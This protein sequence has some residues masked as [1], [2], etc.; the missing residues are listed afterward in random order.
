[1]GI[2]ADLFTPVFA[3]SRIAGWVAHWAE[4]LADNKI[5]RPTQIYAGEETRSYVPIEERG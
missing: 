2:P 1:M 5:F 4:Q 3:V